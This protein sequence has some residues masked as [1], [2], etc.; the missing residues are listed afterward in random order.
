MSNLRAWPTLRGSLWNILGATLMLAGVA[1]V[2]VNAQSILDFNTVAA[3]HGGQVVDL[4]HEAVP[5][6]GQHGHMVR[7]VAT[8]TVVEA[9]RDADFNLS[10]NTPVLTRRVEMFQWREVRVGGRAH[11]EMDWVDRWLDASHFNDPQGH[12]NPARFPMQGKRFDAGLVQMG[13]FRLS[14]VLQHALPGLAAVVPDMRALP[15]NLAASFSRNGNYLQ[16][17]TRADNPQLGDVRISWDE[18]PLRTMTI[19]ARLDGD[20]LLPAQDA[21]DGHGYQVAIGDVGLLDLF[22][23][24]PT[25]PGAV[26]LKRLLGVLL[27][28]L[29]AFV[30]LSV[31][32]RALLATTQAPLPTSWWNDVLLALGA[33]V[34]AAGAV[35]GVVWAGSNNQYMLC[36]VGL[37]LLGAV[38]AVW[39]WR[40]RH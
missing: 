8:P 16:T 4:G 13:G 17:S 5:Q 39:Q 24:L 30:L 3:Q 34:L 7:V 18:I 11:Y 28:V 23:D 20:H 12:A 37:A 15:A 21:A 31:R 1:L 36:W 10:A 29:G 22:P 6:A 19:V 35:A 14:P 32:R 40:R 33:G 25:P 27:T 9:P 2:A 38:L 26:A